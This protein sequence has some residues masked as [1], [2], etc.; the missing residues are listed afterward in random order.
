MAINYLYSLVGFWY[1]LRS[2]IASEKG[3]LNLSSEKRW[4]GV[5]TSSGG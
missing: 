4:N 2:K 1:N 3:G 5:N